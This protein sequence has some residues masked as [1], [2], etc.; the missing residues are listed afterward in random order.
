MFFHNRI[1]AGIKFLFI[2]VWFS[3]LVTNVFAQ[4]GSG[5]NV[6]LDYDTESPQLT[7]AAR[8]IG[9]TIE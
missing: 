1:F 8:E 3:I 7:F 9:Q 5:F 4:R 6:S 2:P